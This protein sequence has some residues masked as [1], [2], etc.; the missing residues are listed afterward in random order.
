MAKLTWNGYEIPEL[1]VDGNSKIGKGVYHFS[2]L[3]GTVEY[4]HT[5]YNFTVKGTCPCD[6]KGCYGMSGNYRFSS[7]KNAL[8]MRTLIARTDLDFMI[9]EIDTEIKKHH[10]KYVRIHATGDFFS[11][12]YVLAWAEIIRRNPD[13]TFWTYTKTSFPELEEIKRQPNANIVN[14]IIPGK[15]FNFGH[16][17]YIIDIYESLKANG[18]IPYICPCGTDK[19]QHC[20][21]CHGCT[22][23]KY[24]L[25][26]EHSTGYKAESD[27]R[28][29]DI[30]ALIESQK[31]A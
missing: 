21:N 8:A 22:E 9:N 2:T 27:T 4:T 5:K 23:H 16:I 28:Y 31:Q 14:S 18:E 17:D 10:I 6:C 1:L 13:C 20:N 12:E 7:V 30:K 15:G 19:N 26:V 29:I 11:K 24:V 25:F 3:P